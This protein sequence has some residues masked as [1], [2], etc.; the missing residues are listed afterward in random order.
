VRHRA[1]ALEGT[2]P[3]ISGQR[4]TNNNY[5]VEGV[6]NNNKSTPAPVINI[7]ND[8]VQNFTVLQ[9]QFSP[10]FGHSSGGQFNTVINSGTNKVH[11]RVYEYF[12][13]RNLNAIDASNALVGDTQNPR[14]DNN[15]FGGQIGGPILRNKI[16]FFVN[17]Q[18]NPIGQTKSSFSCAPTAAGYTF[19]A[20]QP[21]VSALNL[22][23]MQQ[24]LGAATTSGNSSCPSTGAFA[25]TTYQEGQVNYSGPKF[26]NTYTT[27]NSVDVKFSQ[28]DQLRVRY[29]YAR[30]AAQDTSTLNPVFWV[31]SPTRQHLF[32]LSEYHTFTPR[33]LN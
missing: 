12:E 25:S 20:T 13:N 8:A 31:S 28:R 30:T 32:T 2:G 27:L 26:S 6:D 15:R 17:Q 23:L 18:Y 21:G 11:G 19:L 10:E 29:I 33:V 1:A 4:P 5:T 3:S 7:P 22:G 14:Y 9:N 24:Y 16:F